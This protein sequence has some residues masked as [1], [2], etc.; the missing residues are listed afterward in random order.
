M[1]TLAR[2]G[3][4]LVGLGT[5]QG[6]KVDLHS[7]LLLRKPVEVAPA[8]PEGDREGVALYPSAAGSEKPA[9]ATTS[10][11]RGNARSARAPMRETPADA[12][13]AGGTP[14]SRR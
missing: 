14:F 6:E 3:R 12:T 8:V 4:G 1:L 5:E 9:R 10:A 7:P 2:R 11:S 13:S